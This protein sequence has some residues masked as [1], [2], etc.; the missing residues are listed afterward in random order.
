MLG[1]NFT[2]ATIWK[3]IKY[4]TFLRYCHIDIE[5]IIDIIKLT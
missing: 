3:K 2:V 4:R 1:A 5:F